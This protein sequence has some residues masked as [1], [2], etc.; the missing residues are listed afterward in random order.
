MHKMNIFAGMIS[1]FVLFSLC[2]YADVNTLDHF[3]DGEESNVIHFPIG[4][5]FDVSTKIALPAR[6]MVTGSGISI[7]GLP[8]TTEVDKGADVVLVTD[9]SGSMGGT[10]KLGEAK[11]SNIMFVDMA[12]YGGSPNYVG[13]VSYNSYVDF[14]GLTQ[15]KDALTDKIDSYV[16]SGQTCIACGIQKASVILQDGA[17]TNRIMIVHTDGKANRCTYDNP[18]NYETCGD[19]MA[20]IEA[21]Q[22]AH[23][24]WS[25]YSI[26]VYA[27][28]YGTD[29]DTDTMQAIADAGHGE[30]HYAELNNLSQVYTSILID[31][32]TEY[33]HDVKLDIGNTGNVD[34]SH[35]GIFDV[36]ETFT[37][38]ES[39]LNSVLVTCDSDPCTGCGY[40]SSTGE[41]TIDFKFTS[42]SSGIVQVNSLDIV[43]ETNQSLFDYDND[44]WLDADDNCP[45][46]PNPDQADTDGD[47]IGDACDP[48][49]DNDR[50]P[51]HWEDQYNRHDNLLDPYDSD[52]DDDGIPDGDEDPDGDELTNYEEYLYG[53]DPNNPDTD[54]DGIN[55][56][57]EIENGT[58]PNMC[59]TDG[60]NVND[61]DD[62]CPLIYNPGQTDTDQDGAGD[63]CD[64]DDDSDGVEDSIDNCPLIA[65]PDQTDTDQDG[66]GDACDCDDDG[67]GVEDSV[68]NCPLVSNP[69]QEDVDGDD[70][71]DA[72]DSDN[73]NDGVE[74]IIDNCPL[75]ANPA[76]ADTD[77]DGIGDACD[78][79]DDN[80]GVNDIIDNC[81]LVANPGQEDTDGD[82][83]G[84]ECDSDEDGD[85]VENGVDN[86]PLVANPAQADTDSDGIGDACDP[87]DDNDGVN[88]I[89][90]NCP[91]VANPA[92][93]D[94]DN[95]GM[96]DACD[97]D[98]DNDGISDEDEI[99]DGTDPLDPNDPEIDETAPL[100]P[101]NLTAVAI[102]EGVIRL[103]WVSSLSPDVAQYNI[104]SALSETG[105]DYSVPLMSVSKDDNMFNDTNLLNDTEYFY[106]VR[107]ED[108]ASNEENNTNTVSA[109]TYAPYENEDPDEDGLPSDWE[110]EYNQ[111]DN[112]LDPDMN[113]TDSDGIPDGDEDP[114]EDGLTNEDEY[115]YGTDPNNP[116]TDGDG[117]P[118]GWEADNGLNPLDPNDGND[119]NDHDG[120]TNEDEYRYGTD[121]NNP[122]TDGD[123]INDG[124][125]V[126][127]GTDPL[128][129]N[130]PPKE[131]VYRGGGGSSVG[132]PPFETIK[133]IVTDVPKLEIKT[134]ELVR[135][136]VVD[137][138]N[139]ALVVIRNTG[140]VSYLVEV[141]ADILDGSLLLRENIDAGEEY[142][143]V[144]D[145]LPH[146]NDVG[147]HTA[148]FV[149]QSNGKKIERYVEFS[150][151]YTSSADG[152][153]ELVIIGP[154]ISV[155][156]SGKSVTIE[157]CLVDEDVDKLLAYIDNEYIGEIVPYDDNC[158]KKVF[159]L[160]LDEGGHI[161]KLTAGSRIYEKEFMAVISDEQEI[162]D[163]GLIQT[164]TGSL[165]GRYLTAQNAYLI[166]LLLLVVGM[167]VKRKDIRAYFGASN[168]SADT[169][170]ESK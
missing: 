42:V 170:P 68:D 165:I 152:P 114:D 78:P 137:T 45:A 11:D 41:C 27:I 94:T 51:D 117:M 19:T 57:D 96:G 145:V 158:F 37:G 133:L 52:S 7:T 112:L 136:M 166:I 161:L 100:P 70:I 115:N 6:S 50:L 168:A 15:D 61:Y 88:D 65:N 151:G 102:A 77:Q 122:D 25:E 13:L 164:P 32:F 62:N 24:A 85:G 150:V 169:A 26:S 91:L 18:D 157:G 66:I 9:V 60:D 144:F 113:D 49:N 54:G 46:V 35:Y 110:D 87:D 120:L 139:T 135:E 3:Y 34:W 23:D 146:D 84:D 14:M 140:N 128:D 22:M 29:A 160:E 86:C 95:D 149:I 119:D 154:G 30:Y 38:F 109:V 82:G 124:D 69:G 159:K 148:H 16:A 130:D 33:P 67:D 132:V 141:M 98:D 147:T 10:V 138:P 55:D 12:I 53:T 116:D 93:T 103:T 1:V 71:G 142:S 111:T 31:I 75:I 74:D 79:D 106:V 123:G 108:E 43:Y 163:A 107:A 97:P 28:A 127:N 20:R 81:P 99:A 17:N 167:W 143:Y 64:S 131:I 21:I 39:C 89:I 47:S 101:S 118:D 162:K 76:Q 80:D 73:D 121:P 90:D 72:C 4:G 125:E 40:N 5:G 56:G 36:S 48:D 153:G 83:I 44:G 134:I 59:D 63:A 8:L 105:L 104:Y 126:R 156:K 155:D 92:Q 58:N 129:P 2:A